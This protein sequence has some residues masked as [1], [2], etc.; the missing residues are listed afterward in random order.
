MPRAAEVEVEPK[1][2]KANLRL[3]EDGTL[4][5]KNTEL[6]VLL[7]ADG[8]K[9]LDA[10]RMSR[11]K[12]TTTDGGS[13]KVNIRTA[14]PFR[15]RLQA[16]LKS[17]EELEAQGIWGQV[18]W[19]AQQMYAT[20]R[21]KNDDG[22]CMKATEMLINVA[23]L[24]APM[25][26]APETPTETPPAGKGRGAPTSDNPQSKIDIHDIRSRLGRIN[27]PDDAELDS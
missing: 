6:Y 3:L 17:K 16:L 27:R 25:A 21:A 14:K 18:H 10:W 11:K 24:S 15:L 12:A 26:P 7:L 13:Y 4:S 9:E 5:N 20:G 23:K 2:L 22:M 8:V 1:Y 19:Q